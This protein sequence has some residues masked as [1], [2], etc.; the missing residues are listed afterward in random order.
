MTPRQQSPMG[1][2]MNDTHVNEAGKVM[3]ETDVILFS[4]RIVFGIPSLPRSV[5]ILTGILALIFMLAIRIV[6]SPLILNNFPDKYT[7]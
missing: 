6:S 5:S 4:A 7:G 1:S 2:S 3:P